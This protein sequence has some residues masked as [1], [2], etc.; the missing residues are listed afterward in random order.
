VV[1]RR[2]KIQPR[3]GAALPLESTIPGVNQKLRLTPGSIA[4]WMS[5]LVPAAHGLEAGSLLPPNH[6][7]KLPQSQDGKQDDQ[8]EYHRDYAP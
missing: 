4:D 8:R 7:D 6:Q 2:D 1:R 5:P 3:S